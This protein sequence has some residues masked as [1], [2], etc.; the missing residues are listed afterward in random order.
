[1]QK[2]IP[3]AD[4]AHTSQAEDLQIAPRATDLRWKRQ[5]SLGNPEFYLLIGG[6]LKWNE[7]GEIESLPRFL[8]LCIETRVLLAP[9]TASIDGFRTGENPTNAK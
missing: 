4:S 2:A 5:T 1:V 8:E 6:N 9:K 3:K 7:R